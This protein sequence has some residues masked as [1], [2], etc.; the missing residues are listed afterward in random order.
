MPERSDT[1]TAARLSRGELYRRGRKIR[2][3][4]TIIQDVTGPMGAD[5]RRAEALLNQIAAICGMG[6]EE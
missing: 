2:E 3:L 5:V 4:A 1:G 6:E